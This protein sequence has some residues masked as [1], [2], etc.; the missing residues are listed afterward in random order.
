MPH[1]TDNKLVFPCVFRSMFDPVS[2]NCVSGV[3]RHTAL[4]SSKLV[5]VSDDSC[6]LVN[7]V[8]FDVRW[9]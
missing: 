5:T 4:S 9:R 8:S 3:C 7:S 2:F 1:S 6:S